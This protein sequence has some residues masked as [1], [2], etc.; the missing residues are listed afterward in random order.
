MELPEEL[1][2]EL[3]PQEQMQEEQR[4][5]QL[6]EDVNLAEDMDDAE[7]ATIAKDCIGG[8]KND[9]DSREEWEDMH[10]KWLEQYMQ[11]TKAETPPWDG[12]SQ[13]SIPVL[14]EAVNQ[15]Q[16]RSYRAFFPN[17]YFIDALPVGAPSMGARERAE[18]IARHMSWQ[19][20]VK[21]RTYKPNKN[22]MFMAT[23]IDGSDFTKTYWSPTRKQVIVE[24]VRAHD[25]VVPYG[26]GPRRLEEIER[27]TQIKWCSI[28]ETRILHA[29]GWYV[30][31]AKPYTGYESENPTQEAMD[32]AE[33]MHKVGYYNKDDS[34]CCILEQH[35]L[36]DLDDD[37]IAEPYI[38]WIDRQTEKILRIQIRYEVD[39][40]GLPVDNKEP[41]EHFT[42]YQFLPNPN[43]FYGLGFGFLL[44]KIGDA[45]NK[46]T[47][48]FIDANELSVIGNL[49]YFISDQLG[50]QGDSFEMSLGRGNKIPRSVDDIRKHFMSLKFD[51]PSQETMQMITTLREAA[52]R[53]SSSTDIL[54]GQPDKVYQPEAM[55]A[56]IEQGLQL[57][58][59]VQEFLGV[60][61]EDELQKIYRLNAK[62]L[63][64][65]ADFMF[66]DDQ[67]QVTREDYQDDFRVVPIFDPKYATRS[68]RLAKAKAQ[69]EFIINNPLT[70]QD[71]ESIY[72][73]S[74]N[75]LQ[76][77]D[78][79]N[80]EAVLKKPEPPPQA[81]RIDDQN[82]E[83]AYYIMPP[84]KRPLFDV[85]ADQDHVRHME[86]ID[87]FI[88][89]FLDGGEAM[90]IPLDGNDAKL[91]GRV[92]AAGD[93]GIK[94]LVQS[95]STEQ[96]QELIA[97][98]LRHRSLH[99]AYMYGQ[100][101]G[102]M[103][104]QGQ[105]MQ[106]QAEAAPQQ[107]NPELQQIM[108]MFQ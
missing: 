40:F 70:A 66:G 83:N 72:M 25:L 28:N 98:L 77:L 26:V 84:D 6:P 95:M 9:L 97:N 19:L 91:P 5:T 2:A 10:A 82:L 39:E 8:F 46:L 52:Q 18:R 31:E 23:A 45:I 7:L 80:I 89:S 59:S 81:V 29:Q 101:N 102:A 64:E 34:M 85:W 54:S 56:M 49:T 51:A 96:K 61:M 11:T 17:R 68:Q 76:A 24:R 62:Y 12:S 73:V 22:Q 38:V 20:G 74:F 21:D 92:G 60:A 3:M 4:P 90:E 86:T 78:T 71:P 48:M 100:L 50:I 69:Y 99:L 27:K 36:L 14:A 42:H 63:Q 106:P 35:T 105:P 108:E 67:I 58:S 32:D 55:L 1:I 16:S 57:F 104:E 47:R 30:D 41:I 13:D 107:Q 75:Y 37:G 33:G 88:S 87:L 44:G 103:D 65:D 93:P 94:R 53:V 79:E 43:G 15:F